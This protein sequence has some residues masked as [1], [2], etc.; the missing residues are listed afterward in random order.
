[1]WGSETNSE[2]LG[3]SMHL[4][5]G[6]GDWTILT[7]LVWQSLCPLTHL[8]GQ[9]VTLLYQIKIKKIKSKVEFEM[10]IYTYMYNLETV[11]KYKL[12]L[13]ATLE[14]D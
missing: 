7:R 2:E 3:L 6:S 8:I 12:I 4:C 10:L 1:M 11:K 5:L 13:I 9:Q 14:L